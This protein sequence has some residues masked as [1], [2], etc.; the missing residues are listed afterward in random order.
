MKKISVIVTVY[1]RMEYLKNLLICL[2]KQ[3]VQVDELIIADDGSKEKVTDFI[4]EIIPQCKF[5]IKHIYQEDKG[6]RK[7]KSYN[8]AVRASEGDILIFLDQDCIFSPNLIESVMGNIEKGYFI[9]LKIIWSSEDEKEKVQGLIQEESSYKNI[10]D[11]IEKNKIKKLYKSHKLA[12]MKNIKYMIG[13]KDRGTNIVGAAFVFN[14]EDY[15]KINGFDEEYI[16]WGKEDDDISWRAYKAG[17]KSKLLYLE[18]PII[19]MYHY[20]DPTKGGDMNEGLFNKKKIFL[21]KNKFRCE[22]GY[23]NSL[24]KDEVK[25]KILN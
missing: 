6:F 9:P 20:S 22:Y 5:K 13:L 19:H 14:K 8:N 24:D 3:S 17:L 2:M 11:I 7:S 15:I 23:D 1:N 10:V 18:E 4:N 21:N 25:I 16:N 12:K